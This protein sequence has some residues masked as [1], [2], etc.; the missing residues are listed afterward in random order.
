MQLEL[1]D[2]DIDPDE[3]DAE[4]MNFFYRNCFIMH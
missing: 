4:E 3:Y 2:K 1:V